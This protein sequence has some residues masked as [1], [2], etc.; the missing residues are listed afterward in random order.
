[1]LSKDYIFSVF[2]FSIIFSCSKPPFFMDYLNFDGQWPTSEKVV[3]DIGTSTD[4]PVNLMIYI[5]N[6]QRYPFSN[7]FLIA[8]LK[9]GDSLLLCD[10]LEY[11]MTNAQGQWLGKG[12]LEVKESKLWWKENYELPTI[13]NLNV[14]LEHAL[15]FNGSEKSMD[16]LEGIVSVGFAMEKILKDE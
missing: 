16:T 6:N 14:Q 12:F 10:T 8:R 5:R 2:I 9:T 13:E 1:M 15:R 4:Q 11:A 3:F 7:I